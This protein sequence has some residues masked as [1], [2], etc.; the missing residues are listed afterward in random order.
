MRRELDDMNDEEMGTMTEEEFESFLADAIAEHS[1]ETE[2]PLAVV[3]YADAG[4]LTMN[5]GL[6]VRVG[7]MEFQVTIVRSR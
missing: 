3:A 5:K 4:I 1:E 7:E 6:V 2:R